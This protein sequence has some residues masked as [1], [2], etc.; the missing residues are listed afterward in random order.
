MGLIV[1][2][3]GLSLLA[4]RIGDSDFRFTSRVWPVILIV[5]GVARTL[6]GTCAPDRQQGRRRSGYWLI[7][8]GGWGL[9]NE[10][11]FF[12]FNYGTSWPLLVIGA[13]LLMVG[14]AVNPRGTLNPPNPPEPTRPTQPHHQEYRP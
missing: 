13:G 12:G 10:Y 5:I 14:R 7:Y 11:H 4:D 2:V 1:I 8:L 9:I 6:D 3:V